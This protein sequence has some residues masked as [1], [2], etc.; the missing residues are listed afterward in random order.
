[1][2]A[3]RVGVEPWSDTCNSSGSA[4]AGWGLLGGVPTQ[5]EGVLYFVKR[6][7]RA[8]GITLTFTIRDHNYHNE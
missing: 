1:M 2:G 3:I 6:P 4:F 7:P 5:L 8:L